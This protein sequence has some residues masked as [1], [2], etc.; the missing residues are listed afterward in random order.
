MYDLVTRRFLACCSKN[1]R[2]METIVEIDIAGESFSAKGELSLSSGSDGRLTRISIKGLIVQQRNY[3]DVYIYDKWNGNLLPDFQ[4]GEKFIPD[5]CEIKEGV[6][7]SPNYLTEADLVS[8]MDKNG[9]GQWERAAPLLEKLLI[10]HLRSQGRMLPSPSTSPRSSSASTSSSNARA[11]PSISSLR[12]SALVSSRATT[13]SA[14]TN[15]S[16]SLTFGVWCA[17]LFSFQLYAQKANH[18]M[19]CLQTE[20]R[21]TQ[22]CDGI[23]SKQEVIDETLDE[24]RDMFLKTRNEFQT[25]INVRR[26]SLSLS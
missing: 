15:H 16:A 11:I 25:L 9:I 17:K 10:R 19:L 2:G 20:T 6:T 18:S 22:V 13:P 21:M 26:S 23:K 1:A 24:Y 7:S 3:L 14:S 12:R 5:V 4:V 8:L